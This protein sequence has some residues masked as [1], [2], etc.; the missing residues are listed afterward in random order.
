MKKKNQKRNHS[1]F[2]EDYDFKSSKKQR[3]LKNKSNK[4]KLSI[5]D[6]YDDEDDF[7]INEKFGNRRK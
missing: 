6:D 5:Y 4:K 2:E 1:G 7:I 3:R